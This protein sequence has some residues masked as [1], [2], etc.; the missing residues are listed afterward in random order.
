MSARVALRALGAGGALGA[1]I[2]LRALSAGGALEALSARVALRALSTGGALGAR[3]ALGTLSP[4]VALG[5]LVTL[6]SGGALSA[7]VALGTLGALRAML[8]VRVVP[9]VL[10]VTTPGALPALRTVV[11]LSVGVLVPRIARSVAVLADSCPG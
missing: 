6:G 3:V 5:T 1:C 11:R 8:V 10:V 7:R 2:A 9:L 4:R